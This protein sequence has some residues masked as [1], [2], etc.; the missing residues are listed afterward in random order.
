MVTSTVGR[1]LACALRS[2]LVLSPLRSALVQAGASSASG[3]RR[4]S[5]VS[6]A[7]A[8][9]GVIQMTVSGGAVLLGFEKACNAP[10]HTP[11]V[12]PL[13]VLECSKPLRPSF[14]ARQTSR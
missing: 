3:A 1:R 4:A 5:R 8:R 14:I 7:N 11:K 9:I 10:S 6:A 2:A 12:L 13:P